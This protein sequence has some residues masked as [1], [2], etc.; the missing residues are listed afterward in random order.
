M[1]ESNEL[2]RIFFGDAGRPEHDDTGGSI[3]QSPVQ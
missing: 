3:G 2:N 1:T